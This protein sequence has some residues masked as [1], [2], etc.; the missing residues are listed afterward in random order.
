[1]EKLPADRLGETTVRRLDDAR[2]GWRGYWAPTPKGQKW[3]LID[4]IGVS[5]VA[6]AAIFFFLT[7]N[8][9]IGL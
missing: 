6:A 1:M 7:L 2:R 5:T 4:V 3:S 8:G 9:P